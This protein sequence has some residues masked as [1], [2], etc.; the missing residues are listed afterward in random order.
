MF[1]YRLRTL[2]ILLAIGP[3]V[4]AVLWFW[5]VP[6]VVFWVMPKTFAMA[7]VTGA[8]NVIVCMAVGVFLFWGSA[9]VSR[10]CERQK[11]AIIPPSNS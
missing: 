8:V 11:K 1:R 4:L 2:L 3:P 9:S 7:V 5:F 10:R 6:A